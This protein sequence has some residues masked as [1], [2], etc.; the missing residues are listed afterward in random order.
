[1]DDDLTLPPSLA[2]TAH[3]LEEMLLMSMNP[4]VL[5]ETQKMKP[6]FPVHPSGH[7][8]LPLVRLEK[9]TVA[10]TIV[11]SLEFLNNNAS[12]THVEVTDFART[13]IARGKTHGFATGVEASPRIL[14]LVGVDI[15]CLSRLDGVALHLLVQ[16]PT[17]T[18]D[19]CHWSHIFIS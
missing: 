18:D 16:T 9:G 19:Q 4:L 12:R 5:K 3:N 7:E 15:R 6:T 1:M 11:N 8:V 2:G 17:V 10:Q 13:L 14:P